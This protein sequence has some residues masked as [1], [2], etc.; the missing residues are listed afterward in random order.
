[1]QA[2]LEVDERERYKMGRGSNA[3][4]VVVEEAFLD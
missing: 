4:P 1:V 3:T 2:C